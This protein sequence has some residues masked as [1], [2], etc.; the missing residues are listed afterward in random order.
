MENDAPFEIEAS[1]QGQLASR[2]RSNEQRDDS[3]TPQMTSSGRLE[4]DE[5]EETPLLQD[6]AGPN[7]RDVGRDDEVWKNEFEGLPWWKTP[8]VSAR[9]DQDNP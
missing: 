2:S 6:P 5:N 7:P 8:S 3:K 9:D 1:I 4:R